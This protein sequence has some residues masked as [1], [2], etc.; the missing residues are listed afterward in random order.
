V[1]QILRTVVAVV[2]MSACAALSLSSESVAHAEP[3]S[4][5]SCVS[6]LRTQTAG[7]LD[8]K[9]SNACDR[10]LS[11]ELRWTVACED[12]A[13]KVTRRSSSSSR[14]AIPAS[15]ANDVTASTAA[16]N[17]GWSVDDVVWTCAPR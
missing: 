14:F 2:S 7:G 16:C 1:K 8:M 6:V 10:N 17:Q 13:G 11:C 9:V 3:P 12:A 5:N 15:G 4:A